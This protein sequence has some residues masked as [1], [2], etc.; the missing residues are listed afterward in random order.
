VAGLVAATALAGP[1]PPATADPAFAP[2]EKIGM[3]I[4][5]ARLLAGRAVLS[6]EPAQRAGRPVL[7]IVLEARSQGFFAWLTR[8]KVD[9]RTVSA[10]DPARGCS[11]GIEKRLREGRHRRDQRV[12]FDPPTGVAAVEDERLPRQRYDVGPCVQDILSAFFVARASG[13]DGRGALPAVRTFDNGR[14]FDLRFQPSR[15]ETLDLPPPLGRDVP[16]RAFEV[17]LVP[18]TGVFEQQ[19]RLFLWVTDDERRI[20]V[21]LRAKAP[22]GWVS[23]DLESYRPPRAYSSRNAAAGSTRAARRAGT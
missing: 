17:L 6:V 19:G 16:T 5:W 1:L 2:G 14:L 23:A 9:D 8:F 7:E 12:V 20:P 18:D 22:L 15:A 4:T 13:W 10:W 11:L 3:R 21:R